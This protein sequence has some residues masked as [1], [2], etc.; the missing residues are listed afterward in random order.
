MLQ[1]DRRSV[2][3]RYGQ[4]SSKGS[5]NPFPHASATP[6]VEARYPRQRTLLTKTARSSDQRE[7]LLWNAARRR[8]G[9]GTV[10]GTEVHC[11]AAVHPTA[12]ADAAS[13]FGQPGADGRDARPELSLRAN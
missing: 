10:T 6:K 12:R 8:R 4:S 3:F 11:A 9:S 1:A 2:V 13:D 5:V 7:I